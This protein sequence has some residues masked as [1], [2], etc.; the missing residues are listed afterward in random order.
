L[1]AAPGSGDEPF[2]E[3]PVA[4]PSLGKKPIQGLTP[5]GD[6]GLVIGRSPG[7]F[8]ASNLLPKR[9]DEPAAGLDGNG[10][11][12]W[13]FSGNG[14]ASRPSAYS[15]RLYRIAVNWVSAI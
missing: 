3:G 9:P 11:G 10:I 5:A 15:V 6:D 4:E 2:H 12:H 7:P 1:A 13:F 8:Q 14:N